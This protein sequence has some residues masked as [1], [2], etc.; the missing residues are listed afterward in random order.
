MMD[1][2]SDASRAERP[3]FDP[4]P[5]L[6]DAGDGRRLERFGERV[7]DRP[8]AAAVDG[9]RGDFLA[10]RRA[11][12]RFDAGRGWIGEAA[13]LEPWPVAIDGLSLELR[14]TSSGGLGVYPEHA[15]NLAWVAARVRERADRPTEPPQV[16]NLFGHTG[17]VTLAAARAGAA[18]AHVDAAKGAVDWARRNATLS[19]LEGAA[20]RWL[21]DDALGFVGREARRGR[22]YDGIVLDPPSFGRAGRRQWK[23]ADE[24]PALLAACRLVAADD[25]FVLL[26]AHTTGLDGDA[27]QAL[28]GATFGGGRPFTT[29]RLML[30][31]S[32][33]ARL[34]LGWS[35]RRSG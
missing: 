5:E 33:G 3:D 15:A 16:L 2:M 31:A 34:E 11:D 6:L 27:L 21:V 18:V 35:V 25:A 23:L 9:R 19:G 13:A 12:L 1:P 17:L 7:V 32:S 4:G 29:A 8:A 30:E 26:T 24:L 14:P 22:R 28:L 20:V 10:W